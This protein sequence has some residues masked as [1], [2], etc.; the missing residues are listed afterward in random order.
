MNREEFDLGEYYR[1]GKYYLYLVQIF[2][3]FTISNSASSNRSYKSKR[4][5]PLSA[6]VGIKYLHASS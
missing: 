2:E 1:F 6:F 3:F 4:V 5:L